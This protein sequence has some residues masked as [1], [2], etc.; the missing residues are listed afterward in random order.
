MTPKAVDKITQEIYEDVIRKFQEEEDKQ[1]C[2]SWQKKSKKDSDHEAK[3]AARKKEQAEDYRRQKKKKKEKEAKAWKEREEQEAQEAKHH[4]EQQQLEADKR[5]ARTK[6][7]HTVQNEKYS[8]ELPELQAYRKRYVTNNQRVTVNLDSHICYLE[9]IRQD[10]SLYPNRNIIL[11]TWLIEQ[12]EKNHRYTEAANMKAVIDKG[13]SSHA[14]G[15]PPNRMLQSYI[16]YILSGVCRGATVTCLTARMTTMG[17]TR[18][19]VFM[20]WYLSHPCNAYALP[21]K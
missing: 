18:I 7:L 1:D 17:M 4:V 14:P 20:T 3:E 12:L 19:L 8:E 9:R 21:R 15:T 13:F 10:K 6:L 11:G 5:T 16:P 2:Q